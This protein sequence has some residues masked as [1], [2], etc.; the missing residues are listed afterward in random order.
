MAYLHVTYP[1]FLRWLQGWLCVDITWKNRVWIRWKLKWSHH[2]KVRLIF[3]FTNGLVK[4][5]VKDPAFLWLKLFSYFNL[6]Y[7]KVFITAFIV[8][9]KYLLNLLHHL[10][11]QLYINCSFDSNKHFICQHLSVL[12]VS[13]SHTNVIFTP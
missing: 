2:V 3:F 12:N 1:G 5:F 10:T 13:Y 11:D 7:I 4:V 6:A 9:P 8:R